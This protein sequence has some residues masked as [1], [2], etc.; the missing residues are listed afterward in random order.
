MSK[1]LTELE[2]EPAT[3][4]DD[5]NWRLIAPLVYQ[6]DVAGLTFTVPVGFVTN[7]ASVPRVFLAYE[8][9]GNTANVAAVVHDFAYTAPSP[10]ARSVADAVFREAAILTGVP[11]W[12]ADAMYEGV[13]LFGGSHY[14]TA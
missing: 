6:S 1:F 7:Y 2:V 8:L 5:G 10:I 11:Q 9:F 14:N 3:S 13:R 4:L 12:K